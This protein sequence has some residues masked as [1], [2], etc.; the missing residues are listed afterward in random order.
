MGIVIAYEVTRWLVQ[1]GGG[2][3]VDDDDE[4]REVKYGVW[5]EL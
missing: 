2:L 5:V 3:V 1:L 4:W